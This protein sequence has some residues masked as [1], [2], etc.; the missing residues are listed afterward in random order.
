M[1]PVGAIL[2]AAASVVASA[3]LPSVIAAVGSFLGV[4]SFLA[5]VIGTLVVTAGLFVLNSLVNRPSGANME[6]GKINVKMNEPVRW[7]NAGKCRQGGGILFAEFDAAGNLWYLIVHSDSRFTG[8][9]SYYFDETLLILDGSGNV[10]NNDF[11]LNN[12]K[13]YYTSG[14]KV[15]YFQIWTTTYTD[16]NVTP[17]AISAFTSTFPTWTADHK[18]VG[19]T[20]SVVKIKALDI[21]NRYKIYK[22][23]GP[24]GLGEPAVS[25]VADWSEPYDPRTETYGYTTNTALIWAWFRTH[26][27]GM[28]KSHDSIDWVSIAV[29]ADVCD[30]TIVGAYGSQK[31]YECHISAPEN[32]ER[33]IVEQEILITGDA[34]I[35]FNNEGKASIRV[36]KYVTPTLNL[37]RNRD[38]VAMESVEVQNGESTTQGVVVR[39]TDPDANYAVQP[40]APWYNPD[41]Y[42]PGQAATF[43]TVDALACQNHNQAM[44]I[45]KSI[46]KR[47]QPMHKILPTV[48]LR[49]LKARQE[50]I[51]EITYDNV[52]G[53]DYEIVTPVE[54]D[55]AGIFCG[56]GMVPV[57]ADRWSLLSGE[58]KAKP[59]VDGSSATTATAYVT[60]T[61]TEY[62][63]GKIFLTYTPVDTGTVY[64]FEYIQTSEIGSGNWIRMAV[65]TGSNTAVS[66][67]VSQN[68]SYSIR[69]RVR[70]YFSFSDWSTPYTFTTGLLTLS[71]TPVTTGTVG[72]AYAGFSVGV[73]GG[74]TPYLFTDY[75]GLLPSGV[76]VD[77]SSGAIAGTPDTAG[78]Y[79]GIIIRV[80][81]N[82]GFYADFPSFTITVAP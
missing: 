5:T 65:N 77:Y 31:R 58:E 9:P 11:C 19:T 80:T 67:T 27:Y 20:F 60:V 70:L 49:G 35:I 3:V 21:E 68:I 69:Q 64:E 56:M 75:F 14:T 15:T 72:V 12:K 6:A 63:D 17:P 43:L 48:G 51:V 61:S 23:R 45:A 1:A 34:Q 41:H 39:Y 50:R 4:G 73:V 13:E 42:I 28:G 16:A 7:I 52:F 32:K 53:G 59:V 30:E 25:I 36:G 33:S 10:T 55:Q 74:T 44:R 29:E 71:G 47:S 26:P 82:L 40:S 46:G 79:A 62:I 22:H 24:L 38:I 78:T 18:L 66:G 81:D 2:M 37:T 54:V 76:Y 57:N 8:T